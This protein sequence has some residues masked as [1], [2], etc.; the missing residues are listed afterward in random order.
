MTILPLAKI[1]CRLQNEVST[2]CYDIIWITRNHI[3]RQSE[4]EVVSYVLN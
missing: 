3:L 1:K 4:W 2:V